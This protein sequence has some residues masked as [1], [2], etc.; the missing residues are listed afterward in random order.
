MFIYRKRN[1]WRSIISKIKHLGVKGLFVIALL[2]AYFVLMLFSFRFRFAVF[3]YDWVPQWA[4]A[5]GVGTIGGLWCAW[6]TLP[7]LRMENKPFWD[8]VQPFFCGLCFF[9]IPGLMYH[10]YMVWFFPKKRS[11][12]SR[13]M[14]LLFLAPPEVNMVT[15]KPVYKL[16]IKHSGTG[17]RFARQKKHYGSNVN[18]EWMGYSWLSKSVTMAY[19]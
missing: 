13:T 3:L 12:M 15:A 2:L 5:L 14:M 19:G 9:G 4:T 10:D 16:K 18:K 7:Q 11:V 17:S 8:I 1:M 6:K